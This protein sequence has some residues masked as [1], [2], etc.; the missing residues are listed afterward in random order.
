MDV[1]ARPEP[2]W[3]LDPAG[4]GR[5]RWWDGQRWTDNYHSPGTPATPVRTHGGSAKWKVGGGIAAAILL[6][7]V[8]AA[9]AGTE[10]DTSTKTAA[11]QSTSTTSTTSEPTPTT[12][13]ATTPLDTAAA[14][15]AMTKLDTLAVKGRAPKTGYDRDQFGQ[16]W[17]DDVTVAS[18]HNGCDTRNDLLKSLDDI[19]IE[20][21]TQDCVVLSGMLNDPYTARVIAFTRGSS[22]SSAVQIDHVVALEDA[23]Q[24]GAQQLSADERRDFAN[25]P[26]NL[27]P[28]D[29]PTNS[30]KGAGDAATWL[31]PN[32]AYRCTYVSRQIDVKAEYRLWVTAAE[33]SAM[34]RV[35]SACGATVPT[36]ETTFEATTETSVDTEPGNEVPAVPTEPTTPAYVAPAPTTPDSSVYYK[37]C[38]AARAAGAAP[39]YRGQPGHGS[40]LDRDGD[41][42]GC[43]S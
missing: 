7:A 30:Q 42:V 5:L 23:W 33:K 10:D 9:A 16:A 18:G 19:V 39:V 6:V 41:G 22:T 34:Q 27:Q 4:S 43:E 32:K 11:P 15:A 35:L 36:T 40:H 37:N 20:P 28:T 13:A 8:I 31:P 25:D 38:A 3:S 1:Q 21:G 12:F 14:T 29:G 26:R 24:K 17:S 2:G